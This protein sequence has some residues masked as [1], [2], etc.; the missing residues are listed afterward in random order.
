MIL[1]L[2][3]SLIRRF[4]GPALDPASVAF[5]SRPSPLPADHCDEVDQHN[6]PTSLS[7]VPSPITAEVST[8][9]ACQNSLHSKPIATPMNQISYHN[10]CQDNYDPNDRHTT[11]ATPQSYKSPYKQ[12][13][14]QASQ[15]DVPQ[16]GSQTSMCGNRFR[17]SNER[18]NNG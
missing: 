17:S 4:P 6:R 18:Y 16:Y 7:I 9:K 2:F 13:Y 3:L 12:A 10:P 8:A 15:N 5:P 14:V 11:S 1:S